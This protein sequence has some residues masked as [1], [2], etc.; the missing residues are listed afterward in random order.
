MPF[1]GSPVA[2]AVN[3]PQGEQLAKSRQ[4]AKDLVQ[5]KK[6]YNECLEEN[7]RL[8]ANCD[9]KDQEVNRLKIRIAQLEDHSKK[10]VFPL[11][12]QISDNLNHTWKFS[13]TIRHFKNK[14]EEQDFALI[15]LR[16]K[17]DQFSTEADSLRQNYANAREQRQEV[18]EQLEQEGK[19]AAERLN[20]VN[21]LRKQLEEAD[22]QVNQYADDLEEKESVI[23][24][25]FSFLFNYHFI[26]F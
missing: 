1:Q 24:S 23:V 17:L 2:R 15:E 5:Y 18:M 19:R 22:E 12:Y 10:Y 8:N 16:S 20:E 6:L 3:S 4:Q 14:I 9:E 11:K 26:M 25:N 13:P 21:S 7:D